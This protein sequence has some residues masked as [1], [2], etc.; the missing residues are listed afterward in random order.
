MPTTIATEQARV[1]AIAAG[2]HPSELPDPQQMFTYVVRSL[3]AKREGLPSVDDR[4]QPQMPAQLLLRQV[5]P[6]ALMCFAGR[7]ADQ[8][9]EFGAPSM[10]FRP[11]IAAHAAG[12]LIRQTRSVVDPRAGVVIVMESAIYAS[13]LTPGVLLSS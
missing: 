3:G 9:G 7:V 10:K 1:A 8:P 13:K 6:V 2:L 12:S 5:W 4:H 11:A